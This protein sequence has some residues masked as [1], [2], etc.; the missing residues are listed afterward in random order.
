MTR[1]LTLLQQDI[2]AFANLNARERTTTRHEGH[3]H[4]W[5]TSKL[6]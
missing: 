1:T 5:R 4:R 3:Q 2:N 6:R